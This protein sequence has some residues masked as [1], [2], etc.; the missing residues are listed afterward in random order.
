MP[1]LLLAQAATSHPAEAAGS[2]AGHFTWID[3]SI[4]LGYVVLTT[5]IGHRL[6]GKQATIKDFFLGGRRLPWYAVTGSSIATEISAVTF[7]GVPA[8]V[9]AAGGN[10]TYM[11]LGLV[12]GLLSRI[13]VATVLV[14]QYYKHLVYSPYDYMGQ[15]LGGGVRGVTTALFT[16]GGVLAQSSR[17]YL[18]ALILDVVMS[19]ELGA[20]E[21]A[22]G[23][24][25]VHWAILFIGIVAVLWTLIGGIVSVIW[26]DVILFV[27]F[28]LGGL[29]AIGYVVVNLSGGMGELWSVARAGGKLQLWDL[30]YRLDPVKE[31]T[32]WTALFA[33]T[34]GN[35]GAYGTDQLMAQ[36]I[37]CCKSPGQ[38]KLAVMASYAGMA[39][40]WLMFL[41]GAGLFVYYKG[42]PAIGENAAYAQHL[43]AGK[44]IT[45][46]AALAAIPVESWARPLE[47]EALAKYRQDKDSIFPIYILTVIPT[48]LTGLIIAGI[49]AAAISSLDSILAAL[50]QTTMSAVYLPLR[51]R[52]LKRR[53][54]ASPPVEEFTIE[55]AEGRRTI[56]VSKALVI[57]WGGTLAAMAVAI[58]AYKT[59]ADIPILP[60]ALGLAGMVQGALL[61]AFFLAW[62]P[63]GVTGRGLV[64]AAPMSFLTVFAV[65]FHEPWA[66]WTIYAAAAV[67]LLT[68]L[69]TIGTAGDPRVTRRRLFQT[70]W[71][72]LG[73]AVMIGTVHFGY[74]RATMVPGTNKISYVT[75][76]WPWFAVVGAAV[77]FVFGW[78]LADRKSA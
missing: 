28:V 48:G 38:A 59:A 21:A 4:L 68:W 63:L 31:Y 41:V 23:I 7:I 34:L 56:R 75:I 10:F 47:G 69:A 51:N 1:P 62:L 14:P 50:A 60:L 24:D 20:L 11:Q 45:E 29:T 30:D 64:W 57:A 42:A 52:A 39:V 26:T 46:S 78:A 43:A 22:S 54:P 17:V 8:L 9:F 36:R 18:T 12:A 76:A 33:A 77:A 67:L 65:R 58:G 19:R 13:F 25:S 40:T 27:V 61:A 73:I 74:V 2:L 35:I 66:R 49:F 53:D 15:Q 32:I 16:V 6:S 37:F 71:L 70:L 72:L 44:S 3:W 5:W 55:S